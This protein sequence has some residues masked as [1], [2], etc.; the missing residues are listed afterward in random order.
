MPTMVTG[1]VDYN[2]TDQHGKKQ[3]IT[4]PVK[5]PEFKDKEDILSFLETASDSDA[6]EHT[7]NTNRGYNLGARA[8]ARQLLIKQVEGPD[9]S[10]NNLV[11]QIKEDRALRGKPVNDEQARKLAKAYQALEL[12]ELDTPSD[13]G[14]EVPATA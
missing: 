10:F 12:E 2:W 6:K 7:E 8:A 13:T 5:Y 3:T 9:K 11:K 14:A 4:G 1:T